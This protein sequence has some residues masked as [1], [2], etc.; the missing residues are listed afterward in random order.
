MGRHTSRAALRARC[1][2]RSRDEAR[3][4]SR[5]GPIRANRAWQRSIRRRLC[6]RCPLTSRAYIR[7]C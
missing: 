7:P 5:A 6:E 1:W 3:W 4:H 2:R